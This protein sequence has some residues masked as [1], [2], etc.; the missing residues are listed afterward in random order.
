MATPTPQKRSWLRW[1]I[2]GVVVVLVLVVGGPFVYIH[3]IEGD[4]PPKLSL[5][6]AT[7]P[8]TSG[9]RTTGHDRTPRRSPA[10]G[11]SARDRPRATA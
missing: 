6:T 3:F 2:G 5:S 11:R 4:P 1:V 7:T 10:P 9:R 8:T